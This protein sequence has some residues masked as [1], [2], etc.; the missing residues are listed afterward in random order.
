MTTSGPDTIR[1][2]I[3]TDNHVGYLEQD[4]I[5]GDDSWKTFHEIMNLA[6]T[7]DVDMVLQAGD[8][9]HVNKPSRK[10]MYQVIRSLRLNCYGERPCELEL[11]SDASLALDSTFNHLNYEDPNINVAVPVFAISGNHDDSG[12]EAMLCPNDVLA[13]TGLINHFG[14]ITQNDDITVTPL[15]FR[16][17]ATNLALYGLANV[18]DERLFRTF[19]SGNVKFLRPED[20]QEWFSLLAVHQNHASHTATSYLPESFLPAFLNMVVWGHE[21]E[22]LIDPRSNPEK[23]FKVMQ[24]GSSVATSLCEG[25]AVPKY[26]CVLCITG[27]EYVVEKIKLKTVRPF[28]T[29][30]VCLLKDSGIEPTRNAWPAVSK[31]LASEIDHMILEANEEWRAE[32][33]IEG[34]SQ[35]PANVPP[36]PLIRLR[37]EYSG[38]Y[39]VENPRRFSNR[40]VGRVAN[41]NDVV[42]FHK[43]KA[44]QT[45]ASA[46]SGHKLAPPERSADRQVLDNLRVQYLVGE[47]L[48]KE[49]LCLLPENGLDKA[50]AEFVDKNEKDAVKTFVED[51]LR[52]QVA[53]LLKISD[54][55]EESLLQYMGS[56]KK[57]GGEAVRAGSLM[58]VREVPVA[59]ARV[60]KRARESSD[61]SFTTSTG[62]TSTR[63]RGRGGARGTRGARGRGGARSTAGTRS[64]ATRS[65]KSATTIVDSDESDQVISD[66]Q[67]DEALVISDSD[68]E[69]KVVR[70]RA[71]RGRAKVA[72]ASKPSPVPKPAPKTTARATKSAATT[73]KATTT[74]ARGP[75]AT[76][77]A[78]AKATELD[79][80]DGFD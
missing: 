45:S 12:G 35:D 47:I 33:G 6:R 41:V 15:L 17:G 42:Q 44:P 62:T 14:R 27:S 69:E 38:G 58:S 8:L 28:V 32:N 40:Y 25:E 3:T 46:S 43:R 60:D 19:A 7:E 55:D 77:K 56:A 71:T 10:S 76:A 73:S 9:F 39:E 13:A 37:V 20:S 75:Q 70:P 67:S 50:V 11:L 74:T 79:E 65:A 80:D 54:L 29:K 4:P 59:A 53:E 30:E 24:P 23:G 57:K 49:S 61:D 36:L 72:T 21:H 18:R 51:S 26:V 22:C 31:Y 63:G 5:R 68:E 1:I 64:G 52:F 16:K 2:L 48:G 66:S 34:D 78:T